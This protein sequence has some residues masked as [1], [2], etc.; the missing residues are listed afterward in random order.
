M[1]FRTSLFNKSIIRS[2]IKRFWWVSALYALCMFFILPVNHFIK[3]QSINSAMDK[4]TLIGVF[5]LSTTQLAFQRC[6]VCI[7]PTALAVL[8]FNYLHSARSAAIMHSLPVNRRTLYFSHSFSGLALVTLPVIFT[9]LVLILLNIFTVLKEYYSIYHIFLWAGYVLMFD[10]L[11]FCFA[12]FVG[13]FTG[14]SIAH[15]V[16]TYILHALPAGLYVLLRDNISQLLWGYSDFRITYGNNL[17]PDPLSMVLSGRFSWKY[18]DAIHLLWYAIL[19][20]LIFISALYIYRKRKLE[21][22]GDVISFRGI[23][24]VF[25][26][27]VSICC[28]LIGGACFA[29]MFRDSFAAITLGYIISSFFGYWIAEILIQKSFKVW[30]AYKGY[31]AFSIGLLVVLVGIRTD[32]IGYVKWVPVPEQVQEVYFGTA[33]GTWIDPAFRRYY[34]KPEEIDGFDS[35][36]LKE[37]ENIKNI[38]QLHT[39]LTHAP[40]Q[41]RKSKLAE[42]RN[43]IYTLKTGKQIMR[44]Y[45]I[46]E[47]LYSEYLKPIYESTEYKEEKYPIIRQKPEEIK[48]IEITDERT[49]KKPLILSNDS[50]INEFIKRLREELYKT[51]YEDVKQEGLK[52]HIK[53]IDI[54]HSNGKMYRYELRNRYSSVLSWLKEKGYYERVML[55]PDEVEYAVLKE[56]SYASGNSMPSEKTVVVK[57]P[58]IMEELLNVC[59]YNRYTPEKEIITVEFYVKQNPGYYKYTDFIYKDST[60]SS[61]LKKIITSLYD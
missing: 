27:G 21:A 17:T 58:K 37:E 5:D 33:L 3:I 47:N 22:A 23:Q 11:F 53:Y 12:V 44:K 2:D 18:Y 56:Q 14:N 34:R 46:N 1:K 45:C 29:Y 61:D 39:Q 10:I 54:G 20:L 42:G 6:L 57:Y 19:P 15:I 51:T 7:I 52:T 49:I 59:N 40:L 26:Y 13:M 16:L 31:L 25:K 36:F 48:F 41:S 24:P 9:G 32:V 60:V 38:I 30:H 55:L 43:I 4:E 28:T 8:L 35:F 50:E